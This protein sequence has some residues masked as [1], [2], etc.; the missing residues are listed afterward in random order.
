MWIK[1]L[2]QRIGIGEHLEA[3]LAQEF[4]HLK[5]VVPPLMMM[6]SPSLHS[7]TAARAIARLAATLSVWL[8][9][10]ERVASAG[11]S[12]GAVCEPGI[13]SIPPCTRV[14]DPISASRAKSRRTE[15]SE[16]PV[17]R[18]TSAMRT[19]GCCFSIALMTCQRSRSCTALPLPTLITS[20]ELSRTVNCETFTFAQLSHCINHIASQ[21]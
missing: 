3:A 13:A 11:A 12:L 8:I 14:A 1:H 5:V 6:A 2:G 21:Y 7:A 15:A 10:K 16:A 20:H 18:H 4:A 17:A 9:S 19:S